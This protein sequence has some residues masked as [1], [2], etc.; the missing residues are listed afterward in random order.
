M[1]NTKTRRSFAVDMLALHWGLDSD[2]VDEIEASCQR[3][4]FTPATLGDWAIQFDLAT[5]DRQAFKP[6]QD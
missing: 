3:R 2:D 1:T 6:P 4:G 5:L